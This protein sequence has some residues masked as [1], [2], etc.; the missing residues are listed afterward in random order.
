[1]LQLY[2]CL[3]KIINVRRTILKYREVLRAKNREKKVGGVT[4]FFL[5]GTNI[6]DYKCSAA[7][8]GTRVWFN[9]MFSRIAPMLRVTNNSILRAA[10]A[11]RLARLSRCRATGSRKAWRRHSG[12][13]LIPTASSSRFSPP[14]VSFLFVSLHTRVARSAGRK[15]VRIPKCGWTWSNQ[16]TESFAFNPL[17]PRRLANTSGR[18]SRSRKSLII[19]AND[20]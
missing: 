2:S 16:V 4:L 8:A 5:S 10:R 9:E 6:A 12:C 1:M 20:C 18:T 15:N 19:F 7:A 14:F 13:T 17:Q 11:G 3:C